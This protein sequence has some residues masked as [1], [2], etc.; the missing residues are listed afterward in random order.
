MFNDY[1][2]I[3]EKIFEILKEKIVDDTILLSMSKNSIPTIDSLSCKLK[4]PYDILINEAIS[5]PNNR[6]CE[7]ARVSENENIA[8]NRD[9]IEAFDISQDEIFKRAKEVYKVSIL[10][11]IYQFRKG[12][13]L[14]NLANR[15]II[16]IDNGIEDELK[17]YL[18][19]KSLID[20]NIKSISLA[21]G[22]MPKDIY[23]ILDLI[24]DNIYAVEIIEDFVEI[25][26]YIKNSI[27]IKDD[28]IKNI[29]EKSKCFRR[30][31]A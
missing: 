19:A 18:V 23:Q 4:K 10:P 7:I 12:E 8:I 20:L 27:E 6:E 24:I 29:L 1:K 11:Q 9:L 25:N 28:E 3:S 13:K 2:E 17:I 30:V 5:S 26:H 22:V 16:L 21:V 14:T 31:D 15:N